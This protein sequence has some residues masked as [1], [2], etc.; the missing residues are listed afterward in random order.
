LGPTIEAYRQLL[1]VF[2]LIRT[3]AQSHRT[4]R[5]FPKL[6]RDF[7]LIRTETVR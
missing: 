6:F 5:N 4:I 1:S 3:L 2:E 7:K